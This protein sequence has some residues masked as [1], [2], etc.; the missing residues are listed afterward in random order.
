M[1]LSSTFESGDSNSSA[2]VGN[3]DVLGIYFD[4]DSKVVGD[5]KMGFVNETRRRQTQN[6]HGTTKR[7]AKLQKANY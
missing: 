5:P 6:S 7:T 2:F 3:I 4:V 1:P